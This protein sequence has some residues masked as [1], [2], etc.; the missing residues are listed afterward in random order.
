[1]KNTVAGRESLINLEN[2]SLGDFL[3]ANGLC[4]SPQGDVNPY[5]EVNGRPQ[6]DCRFRPVRPTHRQFPDRTRQCD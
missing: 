5:V 1:M 6:R 2:S 4:P 3:T